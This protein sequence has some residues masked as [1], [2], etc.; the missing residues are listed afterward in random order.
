MTD[1]LQVLEV[2][3]ADGI[4]LGSIEESSRA[5]ACP[6]SWYL[7]VKDHTGGV[8]YVARTFAGG[9]C[10]CLPNC[11]CRNYTLEARAGTRKRRPP[12]ACM[13]ASAC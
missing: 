12:F 2:H 3:T 8:K 6:P 13:L 9:S 5:C 1:T 11:C 7:D 4:L 10:L